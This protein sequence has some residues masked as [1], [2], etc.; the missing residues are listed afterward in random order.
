M[1]NK[2]RNLSTVFLIIVIVLIVVI[3]GILYIQ[4]IES[5]KAIAELENKIIEI[6]EDLNNSK[7]KNEDENTENNTTISKTN[8]LSQLYGEFFDITSII[9]EF[10]EIENIKNY[11]NFDYDLDS[12]GI[13]DTVT[14]KHI[15]N[16]NES[17][18]SSTRDYHSLEYNGETIYDTF[19]GVGCAVGIVDLDNTDNLLEIW[20]YDAGPSE[21]PVYHFY[22][23][24]G[25]QIIKM[26]EFD[27]DLSFVCDGKGKVL[28]ADRNMPW[29]TPQVYDSYYTIENNV[30]IKHNLDF[31]YNKEYEYTANDIFFTTSLENLKLFEA[32]NSVLDGNSDLLITLG[33]K[34][35]INKLNNDTKF[36]IIDF[37]QKDIKEYMP[38]D[39]KIQLLDGTIGYLIHPYGRFYIY[40]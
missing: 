5:N 36:K 19:Q 14:L 15:I 20:V 38:R 12:D 21:D 10:R 2:K 23:K 33:E 1:E 40:D 22:R 34:Y 25:N 35:N 29:I 31:S 4:K 8:T 3:G 39:L 17:K 27:I 16:E 28:S 13:T 7:E 30:F 37:T 18:Y 9:K 26:G 32:D 24:V 11:K 6:P